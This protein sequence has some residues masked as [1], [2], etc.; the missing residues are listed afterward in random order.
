M[1]D[2]RKPPP[3]PPPPS[4]RA[5]TNRDKPVKVTFSDLRDRPRSESAGRVVSQSKHATPH[6]G[7]P[8]VIPSTDQ[9]GKPESFESETGTP[10]E[11]V[12]VVAPSG[13]RHKITKLDQIAYRTK[14]T[15]DTA[16]EVHNTTV[17]TLTGVG[18]LTNQIGDLKGKIGEVT[19]EL[20]GYK[21]L[22][23]LLLKDREVTQELRVHREKKEI[24]VET[25]ED[26]VALDLS[27][28]EKSDALEAKK[29]RRQI[30]YKWI[31]GLSGA[32][33]VGWIAAHFTG[34]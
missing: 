3:K 2:D 34:C 22:V 28:A 31:S 24:E 20:E 21:K 27:K 4:T 16:I 5:A 30:I 23:D 13:E 7:Y 8:L 25:H 6:T 9:D 12:E 32:S 15:K 11:G 26:I 14:V 33:I 1:A 18:E 17:R 19:G 10:V 29:D